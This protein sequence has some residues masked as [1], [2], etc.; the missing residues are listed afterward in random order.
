V[1]WLLSIAFILRLIDHVNKSRRR[2]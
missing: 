1:A 2:K